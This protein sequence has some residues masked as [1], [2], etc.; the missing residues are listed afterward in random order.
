MEGAMAQTLLGG[1]VFPLAHFERA[2]SGFRPPTRPFDPRGA[3]VNTYDIWECSQGFARLGELRIARTPTAGGARLEISFRKQATGGSHVATM[4]LECRSDLLCT[5]VRWEAETVLCDGQGAPIEDTRIRE[6]AEVREETMVVKIGSQEQHSAIVWPATLDWGLF[7]AVQRLPGADLQ[8]THFTLID[9]V[10]HQ[11]K[12]G[13][14]LRFRETLTVE[15]G[16]RRVWREEKQELERGTV[17]R[18]VP[19]REG[20]VAVNFRVYHQTGHGIVPI[21]YWVD[22][23]GRLL[24]VLSGLFGYLWREEAQ[25]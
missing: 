10:N 12:P 21:T 9:R 24:L 16:G 5:P 1:D 8:P 3:W 6:T 18:P 15:L 2:L 22:S 20:S 11:V 13:Q 19:G 23:N 7:E 25:P 17:Y 4:T 14:T